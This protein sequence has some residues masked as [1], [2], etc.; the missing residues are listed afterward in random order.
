MLA[1]FGSE[2]ALERERRHLDHRHLAPLLASRG[3]DL[4]ADPARA[5]HD[6]A[7]TAL[8]SLADSLRVGE[9]AKVED[10]VEIGSRHRE[11]PRR[12][13]GGQQEARICRGA[14]PR[15]RSPTRRG[16][17]RSRGCAARARSRSRRSSCSSWT[18]G[19]S[20]AS[21]RRYSF[22]SGGRSYGRSASSPTS[23][24]RPSKPSERRVSAALAPASPAPTITWVLRSVTERFASS[25]LDF[26]PAVPAGKGSTP[27]RERG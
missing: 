9:V 14:G 13:T 7:L 12:G 19:F 16:R 1:D 22:E 23:T 3:G 15:S 21:P 6:Q 5:D 10:S 8:D 27:S 25:R 26:L 24:T 20:E 11:S 18:Y 17:S 4:R 2:H